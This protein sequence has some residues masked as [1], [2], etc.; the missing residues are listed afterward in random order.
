MTDHPLELPDVNVLLALMSPSHE[1]HSP[2]MAW[3][4]GTARFGTTVVTE[5]GLLRLLLNP[6][7]MGQRLDGAY[8]RAMLR[9][10]RADARHSVVSDTSSLAEP[11]IDVV[12][13]VGHKQV[14]DLHLVNLAAS[15]GARLVTFDRRVRGL[16]PQSND[17]V[18]TL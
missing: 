15:V 17:Y 8:A 1:F 7:V 18:V 4:R 13:L 3:F 11:V 6:A 2:A 5:L 10:V 12:G 16:V 9:S 14:T